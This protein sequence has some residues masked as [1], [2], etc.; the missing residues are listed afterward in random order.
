MPVPNNFYPTTG[1]LAGIIANN[2]AYNDGGIDISGDMNNILNQYTA[3]EFVG[4]ATSGSTMCQNVALHEPGVWDGGE[5]AIYP[6][7]TEPA[8]GNLLQVYNYQAGTIAN[9]TQP[10]IGVAEQ[11]LTTQH[12]RGTMR[13]LRQP[14]YSDCIDRFCAGLGRAAGGDHRRP[15]HRGDSRRGRIRRWHGP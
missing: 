8:V 15:G 13:G 5:V 1:Q 9:G 6:A 11:T 2:A 14:R 7:A 4:L 3:I 10:I 12:R